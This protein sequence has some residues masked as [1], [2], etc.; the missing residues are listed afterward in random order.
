M[1]ENTEP[2]MHDRIVKRTKMYVE[3]VIEFE[4]VE[5]VS[6]ASTVDSA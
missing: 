6:V 1:K 3:S 2:T 5:L 4:V